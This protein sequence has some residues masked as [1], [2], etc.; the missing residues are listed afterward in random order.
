MKKLFYL[1]VTC[2][3]LSCSHY[4]AE[5]EAVLQQAGSNRAELEKVLKYYTK[6]PAD[7]LKLRA[8]EFLI[9]NMP[10]KYSKYYEAPWNDVA[11]VRLRWTSSSDKQ[12][13]LDT[14]GLGEPIIKED[15]RCITADY[16]INNIELAFKVWRERPWGKHIPFDAFCEEILPY[17]VGV[18]PLEN[19][20]EK[21]LAS[22]ADLD[23][24]FKEDSTVTA[25][26]ACSK[27]N[28]LLPRFRL[29]KDFP[30]MNYSQL[31]ASARG[32]CE[33]MVALA[34]FSMRALGIPVTLELTPRWVNMPNGHSWNTVRDS[35]GNHISFMGT[36]SNPY[37]P[38]QGSDSACLK[39][40]VYRKTFAIPQNIRTEYSNLPPLLKGHK[41]IKD[42]S[43]E[44]ERCTD[45]VSVHLKYPPV[46]PTG[47]V[48]LA[49]EQNHQLYPVAWAK[50]SGETCC[51]PSVGRNIT[52]FPMYYADNRQTLAGDP[53]W[54][55][56]DGNMMILSPHNPDTLLN[57]TQ[58]APDETLPVCLRRMHHGIFEGAN[59]ADF[60]DA[61][62]LHDIAHIPDIFY[63]DVV[64]RTPASY[65]YARYKSP[66]GGHCNVS[67]IIFYGMEGEKLSGT[68]IGTPGAWI[69]ANNTCDK[70]FDG[71]VSTFYDAIE[72]SGAWTG[73]DF[74]EQKQ[75]RS[76]RYL[77]RTDGLIYDGHHYELFYWT[78]DGWTSLGK[79]TAANNGSLQY[80]APLQALLYMEDLTLRKKGKIFFATPDHEIHW[81]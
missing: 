63:A 6:T 45:T 25:V 69:D 16:L 37:Q 75:I 12:R 36:D 48:Y 60:S 80:R 2:L 40:K 13:V 77:P 55:D 43:A 58:I 15:V 52:Y 27:V 46:T 62:V 24:L 5:I 78:K 20:R 68:S 4:S 31:M 44:Y 18:E 39:G 47:Y 41:N 81:L 11:T 53:F 23:R 61:K 3:F 56:N 70:A 22:F 49:F 50:D 17:R 26:A 71:N 34:A 14:Y 33:A 79:Q 19:W 42:V 65:R 30:A 67:E 57:L 35:M 73:L 21:A 28:D 72:S 7:S 10:G 9:V 64:L 59:Q 74:Q 54:L 8:A 76:I 1:S 51:F 29:D 32:P 38:H 66:E